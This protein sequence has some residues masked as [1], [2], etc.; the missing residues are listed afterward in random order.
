MV[1]YNLTWWCWVMIA[2]LAMVACSEDQDDPYVNSGQERAVRACLAP[3]MVDGESSELPS[4]NEVRE[5]R[6]YLFEDGVLSEVYED[7]VGKNGIYTLPVDHLSGHLYLVANGGL[8]TLAVGS[9]DEASWLESSVGMN[10]GATVRF[11]AGQL[12]LEAYAGAAEIPLTLKRGVARVDLHID[13]VGIKVHQLRLRNVAD[14]GFVFS[15]EEVT[16]PPSAEIVDLDAGFSEPVVQTTRGVFY[17]YEQRNEHLTVELSVSVGDRAEPQTLTAA[18]PPTVR[19]NAV[20][21][22]N[23]HP[24]GNG[25][26][27]KADVEEWDYAEDLILSPD[28]A[29]KLT[30]DASRSD[31]P[32]GVSLGE[33][34][35]RLSISHFATAFT[36]TVDC[37]NVL[38]LAGLEQ[39][40]DGFTIR[41]LSSGI[42]GENSFRIEKKLMP[43]GAE[44]E[45]FDIQFKR[46]GLNEV[47]PEDAIHVVMEKNPTLLEGEIHFDIKDYTYRFGDYAD[48]DFGVLEVPEGREVI[49]EVDS[50]EDQ[51]M[52]AKNEGNG[53]RF[54][55]VGGWRPNDPKADGREQS[56]RIVIRD[57]GTEMNPREEY[58]VTR[59]NYGLPVTLMNGIWWCKYNSRGNS[60]DFAD[61]VL[62]PDDPAVAAGKSLLR[63]LNE[64]SVADYL[65]LWGW[66]YQ[67]GDTQGLKVADVNGVAS[68]VGYNPSGTSNTNT[69]DPKLL[70]PT[71]YEMP[72]IEYYNRIFQEYW[73]YV[74]RDG[75]PYNVYSPWEGNRQVFVAAGNRTD[76][77][78]GTVTL[79]STSHFEV[80][81]KINGVKR[82]SVTFYGP[83]AQWGSGG[84]NTNKFLFACYS[85]TGNGWYNGSWG[86]QFN[87]GGPKDTRIVRFIKSPVEYIYG[88]E[89]E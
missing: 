87:G 46:K 76:L 2:C 84:V 50:D 40:P 18:L 28:I 68:H 27:L 11:L 26:G 59:K 43:I 38:E 63:Y 52:I 78:I 9:L 7:I 25:L 13:S 83:G 21:V 47:Y 1:K 12:D 34:G 61:Q 20:Y 44:A 42:A 74:D 89:E 4:E 71:G 86:M 22:L 32:D 80:Y 37:D 75:G 67:G 57:T 30:I 55:I 49:V 35:D 39:L 72:K 29:S 85:P 77:Q 65:D 73:M 70:A 16:T 10:N 88:W 54:R 3:F 64:C 62:V 33:K 14:R 45:G 36:I 17:I 56:A 8:G 19:R 24:D 66:S 6:A 69:L 58:V 5:M 48:G 60:K 31:I 82:E 23:V 79:P 15:R 81:D 51:W 53:N 41:S